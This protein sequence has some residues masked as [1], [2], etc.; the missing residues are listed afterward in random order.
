MLYRRGLLGRLLSG[1]L[2]RGLLSGFL[3]LGLLSGFLSLGLL[4]GLLGLGLLGRL[5][6]LGLLSGFLSLGLLGGFLSLGLLS[7]LL[8]GSGL[9]S[10]LGSRL[11]S[12][13]GLLSRLL[14]GSG[15]FG[16]MLLSSGFFRGRGSHFRCTLLR[17][18]FHQRGG[19]RRSRFFRAVGRKSGDGAQGQNHQNAEQ[20]RDRSFHFFSSL[21]TLVN[22][23]HTIK[24]LSSQPKLFREL[25]HPG[26][27]QPVRRPQRIDRRRCGRT[28]CPCFWAEKRNRFLPF[29][30]VATISKHILPT[31]PSK[32]SSKTRYVLCSVRYFILY[33]QHTNYRR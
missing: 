27:R 20:Q 5:L 10:R 16:S 19:F 28:C 31:Q 30:L 12:G 24:R 2:S 25:P 33:L 26:S 21:S 7:G 15:L 9:L 13:S 4:S 8:G 32:N 6:S 22:I 17:L 1:F 18:G 14:G 23:V 11:L 3:S 29:P